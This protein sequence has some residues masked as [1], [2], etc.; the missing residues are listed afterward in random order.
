MRE[1]FLFFF[2]LRC[3]EELPGAVCRRFVV[4]SLPPFGGIGVLVQSIFP[5]S[6]R[7]QRTQKIARAEVSPRDRTISSTHTDGFS[8]PR[9]TCCQNIVPSFTCRFFKPFPGSSFL[10]NLHFAFLKFP[11]AIV[12]VQHNLSCSPDLYPS[13]L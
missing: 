10:Q 6:K 11:Q 13:S 4:P 8:F 9:Y 5:F 3:L 12:I 1:L 7:T 2:E